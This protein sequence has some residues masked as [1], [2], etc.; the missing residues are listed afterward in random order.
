MEITIRQNADVVTLV[1]VFVVAPEDQE[2]LLQILQEGTETMFSKQPGYISASF[3]KSKDGRRIV[4]Y[5]QWRS[6]QDVEA[7]R[8][9][10]EI[11]AYFGRVKALA[12]FEAIVCDP[13][14]VHHA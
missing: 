8:S 7:F 13:S 3:H 12:Q 5:G 14:Y 6:A 4:N 10:P 1:N 11:G 2:K 9:K